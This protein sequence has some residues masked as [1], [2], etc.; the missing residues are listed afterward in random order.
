M[1]LSNKYKVSISIDDVSP[2]PKSGVGVLDR[3]YELI[4]E[5]PKIKFTLFIPTCYTR[6][7]DN[8]YPISDYP[9]FCETIKN[10]SPNNFQIG[11]HGYLH[12]I[13]NRNNNDEFRHLGYNDA[14]KKFAQIQEERDKAG[15]GEVFQPIFRPP[16]WRMS[17]AA[18][19][20]A[21]DCGIDVLALSPFDTSKK[22]AGLYN[23]NHSPQDSYRGAQKNYD[24]VYYDCCPPFEPLKLLPKTEIVY[25]ACEWDKNY[26]NKE[27]TNELKEFLLDNNKIE[28]CFT[29]DLI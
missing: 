6:L 24:V 28:F 18:M 1:N 15:L 27:M 26:L 10:L 7:R 20:A 14:V 11:Y 5:F 25:H 12:G 16:A 9:V 23:E 13:L 3:C 22:N 21:S 19:K 29:K 17:P 8:S 2:H 4:D